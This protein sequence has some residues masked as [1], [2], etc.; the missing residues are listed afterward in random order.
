MVCGTQADKIKTLGVITI[1]P[2]YSES[3]YLSLLNDVSLITVNQKLWKISIYYR[4][5]YFNFLNKDISVNIYVIDLKFCVCIPIIR[6][7]G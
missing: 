2:T 7:E 1:H 6:V 5:S 4:F 3:S